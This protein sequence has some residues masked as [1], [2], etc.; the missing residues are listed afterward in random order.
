MRIKIQTSVQWIHHGINHS[1][2]W[3]SEAGLIAPSEIIIADDTANAND[4]FRQ[5]R[6]GKG[7]LWQDDYVNA[8]QMLSALSRRADRP[9]R[10]GS[11]KKPTLPEEIF[12]LHRKKQGEKANLLAR[13]LV[14]VSKEFQIQLRRGQEASQALSQVLEPP[15]EDFLMSL[16]GLLAIISA[17]EWQKKG[18]YIPFLEQKI[19]PQYGVFSPVRSEYIDLVA[20]QELPSNCLV[21]IE[22]GVGS[23]ILTAVLARK[24]VTKIIATDI[25]PRAIICAQENINHLGYSNQVELQVTDLFPKA[26]ANLIVCNPPWLPA[27]PS[28]PIEHAV[29]DPDSQFLKSFLNKVAPYLLSGGQVW[30]ILSDLAEHL[31]LRS[32]EELLDWIRLGGLKIIERKDILPKHPKTRN[33]L[34][35]LFFARSKEITSLWVL[36]LQ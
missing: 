12:Y 28:S 36:G 24:G 32:R 8:R 4:L 29:F 16:R 31:G 22:I 20:Q 15:N 25:D 17:Y 18:T 33:H 23:G 2:L 11:E 13:F 30:L 10:V 6:L 14:P 7:V 34:D 3:F 26:K 5:M 19:F 1:C 27:Q 21:A 35:P 9:K